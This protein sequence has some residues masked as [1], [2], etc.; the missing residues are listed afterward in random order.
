LI[1]NLNLA[2]VEN[3]KIR[4]LSKGYKQ[5]LKL[6]LA[7]SNNKPIVVL[8]E[9]F[10]GFDPIQLFDIL[11]LMKS[12][13][14][15]GRTFLISI[16]QLHNA[17]KICNYYILLNEGKVV[18]QGTIE[19]LRQKFGQVDTTLEQIFIAALR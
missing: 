5:R 8:D 19:Q 1:D 15:K 11:E 3:K 17:E 13:N 18:A 10:D 2:A 7:L 6:F 12:E 9:P 16:H 14:K 4:N